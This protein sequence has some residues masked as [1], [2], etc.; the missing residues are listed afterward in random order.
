MP[1]LRHPL[2]D[3]VRIGARRDAEAGRGPHPRLIQVTLVEPG[4]D[5][6]QLGEQVGSAGRDSAEVVPCGG[7]GLGRLVPGA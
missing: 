6:C 1:S 7:P 4:Q 5:A 3:E 2:Q